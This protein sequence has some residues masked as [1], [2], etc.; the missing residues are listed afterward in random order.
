MSI[1]EGEISK[2]LELFIFACCSS[3]DFEYR[4]NS[5]NWESDLCL[6]LV[7]R[8]EGN[9]ELYFSDRSSITET[10]TIKGP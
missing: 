1:L 6:F 3:R 10:G 4:R 7:S 2:L 5:L 9:L 8:R